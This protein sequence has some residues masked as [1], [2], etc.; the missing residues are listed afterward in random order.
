MP[1]NKL[2]IWSI[3]FVIV[4][5]MGFGLWPDPKPHVESTNNRVQVTG[6]DKNTKLNYATGLLT[7]VEGR[8]YSAENLE[9]RGILE[10]LGLYKDMARLMGVVGNAMILHEDD[11]ATATSIRGCAADF[12][13]DHTEGLLLIR[14][15]NLSSRIKL[16]SWRKGNRIKLS[17]RFLNVLPSTIEGK[18]FEGFSGNFELFLVSQVDLQK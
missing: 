11:Y 18:P 3:A 4:S 5:Q 12:L 10:K 2:K 6:L 17:G 9:R 8:I 7:T 16:G 1:F 14:D 13:N 15:P